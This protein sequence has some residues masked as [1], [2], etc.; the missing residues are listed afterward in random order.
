ML[1]GNLL[2]VESPRLRRLSAEGTEQAD[3]DELVD[4][5]EVV[6]NIDPCQGGVIPA[7][8]AECGELYLY[9]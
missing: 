4:H 3:R 6:D 8:I 9:L 5:R 7:K 1:R 2:M